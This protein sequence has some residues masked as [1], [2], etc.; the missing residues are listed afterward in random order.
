MR[1]I[2][3]SLKRSCFLRTISLI[4]KNKKEAGLIILFDA[5]FFI[6]LF[7]SSRL[8]SLVLEQNSI[9]IQSLGRSYLSG[10][11]FI[12]VF[13]IVYTLLIL[14]LYSIFKIFIINTILRILGKKEVAYSLFKRMVALNA[15]LYGGF[16]LVLVVMD[17]VIKWSVRAEYIKITRGLFALALFLVIYLFIMTSN[18]FFSE[19]LSIGKI[20]KKT[21]NCILKPRKYVSVFVFSILILMLFYTLYYII[22]LFIAS[23]FINSAYPYYVQVFTYITTGMFYLIFLFFNRIC[24]FV[25]VW[26]EQA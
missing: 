13:T 2:I 14:G 11:V 17:N 21:F 24:F 5:L 16:L 12:G 22:A 6:S 19:G 20:L 18:V 26:E 15:L 9:A 1:K 3:S 25:V 10:M 8:V 4:R 23:F 7:S